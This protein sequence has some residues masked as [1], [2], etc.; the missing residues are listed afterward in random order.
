MAGNTWKGASPSITIIMD[1]GACKYTIITGG[2][3]ARSNSG[4]SGAPVVSAD[5]G[6]LCANVKPD[7][8]TQY[9][10]LGTS[11]KTTS[12]VR[13]VT[14]QW[15]RAGNINLPNEMHAIS[16]GR[17]VIGQHTIITNPGDEIT[18]SAQDS[19]SLILKKPR[20]RQGRQKLDNSPAPSFH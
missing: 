7:C 8:R 14:N 16:V 13:L 11:G 19:S 4:A 10:T 12:A 15:E 20:D 3:G 5:I 9:F 18:P 6:T 1:R 17:A 2:R